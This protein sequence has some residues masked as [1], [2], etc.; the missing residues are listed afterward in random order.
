[1]GVACLGVVSSKRTGTFTPCFGAA[2]GVP[3]AGGEADL[4]NAPGISSFSASVPSLTGA[5][6][7]V[8]AGASCESETR[9]GVVELRLLRRELRRA[10]VSVDVNAEPTAA[11]QRYEEELTSAR[12][13]CDW[14]GWNA[15]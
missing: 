12:I 6:F 15:R 10:M 11:R 1:M 9:L 8:L 4:G 14:P 3:W 2:R 7:G 13:E 5:V